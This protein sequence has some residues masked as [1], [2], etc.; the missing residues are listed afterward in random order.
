MAAPVL[1][2]FIDAELA[3]HGL[4]EDKLLLVGFSQGTM[5]ALHV[6]LRRAHAVAGIIGYSGMLVAPDTLEAEIRSRPPVLLVHGNADTVVPVLALADARRTLL[7]ANVPVE[8]H[9]SEGLGHSVDP[10]GLSLGGTFA[11][12]T[13]GIAG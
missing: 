7:A 4:T 5:M 12:R 11:R 3:T 1:D 13:L 2:D 6:G 8:V 9:V 10:T